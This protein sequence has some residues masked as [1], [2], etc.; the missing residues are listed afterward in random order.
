M[1]PLLIPMLIVAISHIGLAVVVTRL[2][3]KNSGL[4]TS[5]VIL[6]KR[7]EVLEDELRF[8]S[9]RLKK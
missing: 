2:Q 1:N 8:F 4:R 9:G 3:D 6:R 5:N 7:L